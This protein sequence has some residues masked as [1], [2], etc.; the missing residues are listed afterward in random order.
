MD[1]ASKSDYMKV[2]MVDT[3]L[4]VLTKANIK[5]SPLNTIQTFICEPIAENCDRLARSFDNNG[6]DT[7]SLIPI[8]ER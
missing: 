6:K 4:D 8:R 3:E 2:D 7:V 5:L 1:L